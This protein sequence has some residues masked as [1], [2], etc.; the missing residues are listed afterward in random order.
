MN[1]GLFSGPASK[2]TADL[3]VF[4]IDEKETIHLVDDPEIAGVVDDAAAR[5]RPCCHGT[6]AR[7]FGIA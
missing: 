5:F 6:T 4:L 2:V 3:L 7:A 1:I